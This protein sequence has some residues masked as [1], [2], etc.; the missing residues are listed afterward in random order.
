MKCLMRRDSI[1]S[2]KKSIACVNGSD[3]V[4][5][6]RIHAQTRIEVE[7]LVLKPVRILDEVVSA[8]CGTLLIR[9][10]LKQKLVC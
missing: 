1:E 3:H 8:A 2:G 5:C 7:Q 9:P 4:V 10:I 6:M